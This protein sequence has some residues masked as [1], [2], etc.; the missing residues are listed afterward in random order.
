MT[1]QIVSNRGTS[2]YLGELSH[3]AIL[4]ALHTQ[5]DLSPKTWAY[6][7]IDG[8]RCDDDQLADVFPAP[9]MSPAL[10]ALLRIVWDCR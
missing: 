9:R 7:R 1:I 3:S 10:D 6:L 5:R 2:T 4:A 8:V